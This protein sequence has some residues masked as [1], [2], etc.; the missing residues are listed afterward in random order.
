[1]SRSPGRAHPR[2]SCCRR[3]AG[4]IAALT[5]GDAQQAEVVG[6]TTKSVRW[7]CT[8][9]QTDR[10]P[11]RPDGQRL[12]NMDR[13]SPLATGVLGL[14]LANTRLQLR[15]GLAEVRPRLES[16]AFARLVGFGTRRRRRSALRRRDRWSRVLLDAH[17][18]HALVHDVGAPVRMAT[19]SR[20]SRASPVRYALTSATTKATCTRSMPQPALASGACA[21]TR[22]R[23]PDPRHAAVLPGAPVRPGQSGEAAA[24]NGNTPA[25]RSV[26]ASPCSTWRRS[27]ALVAMSC[28][29][30]HPTRRRQAA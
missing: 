15:G 1:V 24:A 20:R 16:R 18:L 30:P 12:L 6:L 26:A 23:S 29:T 9:L 5:N 13:C 10:R 3:T 21:S 19:P 14:R 17:R 28:A 27:P 7:R 25:A 8:R 11:I 2:G 4:P 22:T